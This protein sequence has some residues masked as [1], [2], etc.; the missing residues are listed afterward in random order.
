MFINDHV[1]VLIDISEGMK[2]WR[3][4]SNG[5]DGFRV[6]I[7]GYADPLSTITNDGG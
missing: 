6:E 4:H 5:G 3:V 2:H 7:P 1:I